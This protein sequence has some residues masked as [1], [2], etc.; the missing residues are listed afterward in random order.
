MQ[1]R[2]FK[3]ICETGKEPADWKKA[4]YY[5]YW[6]HKTHHNVYAHYGIRTLRY[7]LIYYYADALGQAGTIDETY[8]PEWELFDLQNDPYELNNVY[9]D[10][11]YADVV[12]TLTDDLHRMQADVGDERYFKDE[13]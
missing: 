5:R 7:K 3:S 11:A 12:K 6:M 9:Q 10:P 8:E 13:T 4:A 1:G 2:S